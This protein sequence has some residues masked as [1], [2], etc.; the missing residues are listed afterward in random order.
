[1]KRDVAL[2]PPRLLA[3]GAIYGLAVTSEVELCFL[4]AM[5]YVVKKPVSESKL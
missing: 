3:T 1:M 5:S 4:V 2:I